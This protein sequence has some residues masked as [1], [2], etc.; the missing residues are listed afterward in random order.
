MSKTNY[1]ASRGRY[2]GGTDDRLDR[3]YVGVRGQPFRPWGPG[4]RTKKEAMEAAR[5]IEGET[6]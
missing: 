5:Q 1:F 2:S 4:Y 3:W 6:A